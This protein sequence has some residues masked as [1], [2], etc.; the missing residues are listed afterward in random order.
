LSRS[1]ESARRYVFRGRT[2]VHL[3][4]D[5]LAVLDPKEF[6]IAKRLAIHRLARIT[7]ERFVAFAEQ[8][9]DLKELDLLV[10]RP[11]ASK[12]SRRSI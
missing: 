9:L 7:H 1:R 12:Y 6:G 2:K 8:L 3:H 10:E 5:D 11:A 4:V